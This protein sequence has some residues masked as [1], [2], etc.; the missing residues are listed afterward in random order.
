M[1]INKPV[2]P[3]AFFETEKQAVEWLKQYVSKE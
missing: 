3:T 2:K 1:K